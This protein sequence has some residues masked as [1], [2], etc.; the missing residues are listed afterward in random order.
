MD[1]ISGKAS[2]EG[3]LR[4]QGHRKT[5][6]KPGNAFLRRKMEGAREDLLQLTPIIVRESVFSDARF[7]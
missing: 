3:P 6:L 5:S 2:P 7:Q 1:G 4:R